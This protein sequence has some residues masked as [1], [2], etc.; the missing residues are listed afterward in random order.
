MLISIAYINEEK[1]DYMEINGVWGSLYRV[2]IWVSRFALLNVLWIVATLIG[3][4]LLGIFPATI[5]MF[6]VVR[7]WVQKEYDIPV[8]RTFYKSFKTNFLQA[9]GFGII[10]YVFGYILSVFLKYTGL[11]NDSVFHSVLLG[12]F[13][14]AAFF[15]VMLLVY[16]GPVYVHY[17][18]NF[19]QYI[20][21]AITIGAVNL[22]YSISILTLLTGVYFLTFHYPGI[23]L[24]FSFS[25]SAYITML[26][27]N[28]GFEQLLK[29]QKQARIEVE[30]SQSNISTINTTSHIHESR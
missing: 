7:K 1:G 16:I 29:K 15:Y 8:F 22:H 6:T 20:R 27:A 10:T 26:L 5:A 13:V 17:N 23:S 21:Y 4:I 24:V 2:S 25:V 3:F 30:E 12:I 19:W 28:I 18:L 11:M 9:N 14:L